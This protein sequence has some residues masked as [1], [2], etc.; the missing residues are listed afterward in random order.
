MDVPETRYTSSLVDI[1]E[2]TRPGTVIDPVM[3]GGSTTQVKLQA[4]I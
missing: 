4:I 1:G 2:A 3:H